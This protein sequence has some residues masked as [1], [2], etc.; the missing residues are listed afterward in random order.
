VSLPAVGDRIELLHMGD[1]PDP[2]APGTQGT[3]DHIGGTINGQTQIGV[4]WDSGRS[5]MVLLP[6]DSIR[7]L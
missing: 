4:D 5:L 6:G 7:I 2:I 3:V 1:D